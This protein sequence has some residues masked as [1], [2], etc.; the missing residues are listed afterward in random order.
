MNVFAQVIEVQAQGVQFGKVQLHLLAN[1][2]RSIHQA[3]TF[4]HLLKSQ[5]VRFPPQ[6]LSRR[7]VIAM[8]EG[9]MLAFR[10]LAI[11]EGGAIVLPGR[12]L[13]Q[14]TREGFEASQF[15]LTLGFRS[16]ELRRRRPPPR[17]EYPRA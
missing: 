1:P 9:H 5:P 10:V 16:L 11:K 7:N 6:Q 12:R 17:L 14:S 8:S 15:R 13:G 4:I 3:H 2:C